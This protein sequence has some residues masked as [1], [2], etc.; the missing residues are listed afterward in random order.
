MRKLITGIL[1]LLLAACGSTPELPPS[2]ALSRVEFVS[3]LAMP[4]TQKLLY[5]KDGFFYYARK[6]GAVQITDNEGRPLKTLQAKDSRGKPLLKKPEAV[7]LGNDT[8]YVADSDTSSI[9]M[10]STDGSYRGSFGTEGSDRHEL[11]EPRGIAFYDGVLYV[12][13]SGNGRI[14]LFGDNG[15]FLTTLAISDSPANRQA[16][17]Q[18]LPYTLDEPAD[19]D[20]DAEGRIY[21]LDTGDALIKVYNQRGDYLRHQAI[22]GSPAA[23]RVTRDGLYI[24]DTASYTIQKFNSNGSLAYVFG[25]KG[26]GRAQFMS[27]AGLAIDGERKIFVGDSKKGVT[28]VFLAEATE[29]AAASGARDHARPSVRALKAF[30]LTSNAIA[31]SG[32]DTVYAVTDAKKGIITRLRNGT[33]D[34][35]LTLKQI[36]PGALATDKEG[37]LWA[38]DTKKMRIVNLDASGNVV[39]S[40]GSEGS[41]AGQLDEPSDLA[42]TSSGMVFVADPGNRWIQAFSREGVFLSAIRQGSRGK[43]EKP[44]AITVDPRDNVYVLD[45]GRG[46]VSVFSAKGEPVV[47]FGNDKQLAG[48]LADPIDLMVTHDEVHVLEADG[49]KVFT[50]QGTYLH[51]YG[52]E[53]KG[54]GEF[55]KPRSISAIDSTTFAVLD[56]GNGRVQTFALLHKPAAP[57][58]TKAEARVHAAELSWNNPELPY[59]KHYAIYRATSESG[60]FTRV[61]T[62]SQ[63]SYADLDLAPG[64]SVYYRIVAETHYGHEGWPSPLFSTTPEKYA[65]PA[66]TE[67]QVEAHEW[68][69]RL[70]WKPLESKYVKN[71]LIYQKRDEEF[72]KIGQTTVPEYIRDSLIPNTD[73]S[74]YLSALSVDG[75]ESEKLLVSATT[76]AHNK[77]PLEIETVDL[78]DIF[79]N[80]YKLYEKDGLGKFKLTNNT[81]LPME[82]IKVTFSIKNFMD[83]PTETKV[84]K[85]A[86]GETLEFPLKAVFNNQILTV[87]EDTPV[88]TE[89][90]ASYFE[91][92]EQKIYSKTQAINVYEKHRLLWSEPKRF[93]T[94]I[95][96]KDQV[97]LDYA[98]AVATQFPDS[99]DPLQWAASIFGALG[100]TGITYITDPSNPYQ[101]T[102]GA[103]D[104]VDF[105]QYPRET[106]ERKS[107]DCDDLVALYSASL[108][109]MGIATRVIEVPGHMLMMLSTGISADDDGYTMDDMYV[110]HDGVLWIPVETTLIG[111]SF[112]KAWETGSETYTK[113]K[114]K[115]LTFLNVHEA[116]G[117]YKPASLPPSDTKLAVPSRKEIE[118]RFPDQHA[119]LLSI[120]SRTRMRRFTKA[121]EQNPQDLNA[122]LQAG[123]I[124]ARAGDTTEALNYF[125]TVLTADPINA[126]ALNNRGNL[127][128]MA[129]KYQEAINDYQAAARSDPKDASIWI[130]LAKSYKALNDK[131]SAKAAFASAQKIDPTIKKRY[132]TLELE[133]QAR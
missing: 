70:S 76:L 11:S 73:Y 116:W 117:T 46:C 104:M 54:R 52:A 4:E 124:S 38:I 36:V 47:E 133:L 20:L 109:S 128:Y 95:T 1:P 123:I 63:H 112:T 83:F 111:T 53:G 74:F 126:M 13:D 118:A 17:E 78:N 82:K 108:E 5:W 16:K 121:I 7:T 39:S 33:R 3:E 105:I 65:P 102:S 26:A 29:T 14:Q 91:N 103:T 87:T 28:G 68:H 21:V 119:T 8:V 42:I 71:Y 79:S 41:G 59:I 10:F 69:L 49:V 77:A 25:S 127:M 84:A 55:T 30:P 2:A 98:R 43:L 131:K 12:A 94:F 125:Q 6:D 67:V 100:V 89:L 81:A 96:P 99:R 32:T 27:I 120:V 37:T 114:D 61:G 35:T 34:G 92:G 75:L 57:T 60:N 18:K 58:R 64:Q 19:I 88:Q 101:I 66:L 132:R 90:V 85:L 44:S 113:W 107:G 62:T 22:K 15:V 106:L 97:I 110:I 23:F 80:S 72:V 56:G 50:L 86:P 51:A 9:A 40:F 48:F 130:N 24:A 31:V 129:E 93:A 45:S 122:H 115:G